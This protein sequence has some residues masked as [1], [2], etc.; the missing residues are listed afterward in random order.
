MHI[1][2]LEMKRIIDLAHQGSQKVTGHLCSVTFREAADFG[3]DNLEHGF[4]AATDFVTDKQKDVCPSRK[5]IMQSLLA[6]P[7]DSKKVYEL[8]E[9]LVKNNVAIT[10]TLTI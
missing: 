2:Q 9:H 4:V 3:I 1:R 10:S 5:A 6:E 8:I 7:L